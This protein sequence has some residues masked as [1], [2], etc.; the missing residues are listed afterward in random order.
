MTPARPAHQVCQLCGNDDFITD[1]SVGDE[2]VVTCSSQ[3]HP[4]FEW[5]PKEQCR[6]TTG[7]YRTGI[8]QEL[9]VY[10]DLLTCVHDGFAQYGV[11]EYQNSELSPATYRI[12]TDRFG[13]KALGPAGYS[14][15]AFLD[16]AMG[17]LW[18]ERA[19]LGVRP[20][21]PGN[22]TTGECGLANSLE[23]EGTVSWAEFAVS[24]LGLKPDDGPPLGYRASGH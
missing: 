22:D 20:L 23:S 6:R 11:I 9:G 3:G 19:S 21:D 4:P 8:D 7:T 13:H 2:W 15:S 16:G 5:R 10:D 17:Q 24:T 12:L 14:A 18:R 1:E